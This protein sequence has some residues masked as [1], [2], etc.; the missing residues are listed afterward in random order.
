MQ[1]LVTGATGFIGS[2]LVPFLAERGHAVQRMTRRPSR[3][4]DVVWNPAHGE[5]DAASLQ[6]PEAVVHLAGEN[7]ADGRWT[8]A[9]KQRI[10][11]SR[12]KGTQLLSETLAGLRQRPRVLVSASAVG[13]YGHRGEEV[14]TE[15]SGS[16]KGFLAEVCRQWEA[17]TQPAVQA[18]IHTVHLRNGLVLGADGGVLRTILPPFRLGLGGPIGSGRQYWSWI[19]LTDMLHV[20]LH[21][22]GTETLSGPVNAV[23]P[24]PVTTKEFAT[25]LGHVLNRPTFISVPEFAARLALG[26]MA[27]ELLFASARVVPARLHTSSYGFTHATLDAALRDALR[28]HA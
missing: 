3:P 13:Y 20:I 1:V 24:N 27:N 26:E 12:V 18:G 10:R 16:G 2:H 11:D 8:D 9:K 28:K 23:A 14:L 22:V 6:P 7:I 4:G 19:S 15:E 21:C 17:A 25:T 5:I